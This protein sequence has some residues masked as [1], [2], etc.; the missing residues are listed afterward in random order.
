MRQENICRPSIQDNQCCPNDAVS[1]IWAVDPIPAGRNLIAW[2]AFADF[3]FNLLR[4]LRRQTPA[5]SLPHNARI[6]G[7]LAVF[8]VRVPVD[9]HGSRSE[10]HTSEL[11]SLR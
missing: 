3:I 9:G 5:Q 4:H 2:R 7:P 10:E 11:Q 8:G 1:Y 6:R